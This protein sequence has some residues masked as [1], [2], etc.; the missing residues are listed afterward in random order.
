MFPVEL[1]QQ[2]HRVLSRAGAAV[3]F[4]EV[5]DLSHCYP[6]ELNGALLNWLETTPS[7]PA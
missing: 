6:R 2:A 4:R 7:A 5:E 3:T 1:A